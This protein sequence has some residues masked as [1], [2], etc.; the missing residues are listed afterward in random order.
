MR[1]LEITIDDHLLGM[2]LR[3][4]LSPPVSTRYRAAMGNSCGDPVSQFIF[5]G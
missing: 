5:S 3:L 2:S 1:F 4:F